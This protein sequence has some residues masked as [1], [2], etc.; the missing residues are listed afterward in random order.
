MG[1]QALVKERRVTGRESMTFA[2]DCINSIAQELGQIQ[3]FSPYLDS[4]KCNL[5]ESTQAA[6]VRT[7]DKCVSQKVKPVPSLDGSLPEA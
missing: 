1:Q 2:L 6:L 3:P 5:D 7:F 4:A